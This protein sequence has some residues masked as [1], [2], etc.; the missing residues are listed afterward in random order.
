MSFRIPSL[1]GR[2]ERDVMHRRD[3]NVTVTDERKGRERRMG[4]D[5]FIT[6]IL[7]RGD[8]SKRAL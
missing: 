8:R 7:D 1:Q 5:V 3:A 2:R 4:I 6:G